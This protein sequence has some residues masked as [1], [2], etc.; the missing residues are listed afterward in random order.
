MQCISLLRACM[1][2]PMVITSC[3]QGLG[4]VCWILVFKDIRDIQSD[5]SA[6]PML[7]VLLKKILFFL[8]PG[9]ADLYLDSHWPYK[10]ECSSC[11]CCRGI[12]TPICT[13]PVIN[14]LYKQGWRDK[15]Q[16]YPD[17]CSYEQDKNLDV[18]HLLQVKLYYVWS[19]LAWAF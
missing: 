7:P 10:P 15:C 19:K 5:I 18:L 17:I 9:I 12:K 2:C 4:V 13:I 6:W 16:L 11:T 3:K 1:V 14:V 8:A